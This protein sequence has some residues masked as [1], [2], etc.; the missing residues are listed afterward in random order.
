MRKQSNKLLIQS[1][2]VGVIGFFLF[3][4]LSRF[5]YTAFAPTATTSFETRKSRPVITVNDQSEKMVSAA[6]LACGTMGALLSGILWYTF[7]MAKFKRE[8][9][10][11]DSGWA[12]Y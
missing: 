10:E 7:F 11:K 1:L 5:L 2:I 6:G 12:N 3:M 8:M 4:Y 9:F